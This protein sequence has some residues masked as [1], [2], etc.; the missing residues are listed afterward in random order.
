METDRKLFQYLEKLVKQSHEVFWIRNADYSKQLYINPAYE[1][2]WGRTCENLYQNPAEFIDTIL[3]EDR[4]KLE[5]DIAKRNPEVSPGDNFFTAYRIARPD[6]EIRWIEDES[7]AIFDD[8]GQ[9]LGFAGTA[10]DITE[11]KKKEIELSEAKEVAEASDRAKS[12]FIQ[13]M[14]HDVK[15]PL[16]GITSMADRIGRQLEEPEDLE[17]NYEN[18][19]MIKNS[20]REL[21]EFF[22]NCLEMVRIE[23]GEVALA[24]ENFNPQKIMNQL[25]EI[26]T[27]SMKQKGLG[28]NVTYDHNIPE[29]VYASGP[30]FYR[31]LLNLL[32]NAIKFTE[33][34]TIAVDI[35]LQK[36]PESDKDDLCLK[37][38]DTG[39]GI[40]QEKIATI[41]ERFTRLTP[42]YEG[43]FEGHGIG[44]Y[45]VH[46]FV[47]LMG[48][49]IDVS[50]ELGKGSCFTITF[51]FLPAKAF[52]KPRAVTPKFTKLAPLGDASSEG[53]ETGP[54][55]LLVEDNRMA[56]KGVESIL[57]HLGYKLDIVDTGKKALDI[58]ELDKYV[59][60][61]TDIGLDDMSGTTVA[62]HIRTVEKGRKN[63]VPIVALTA[64]NLKKIEAACQAAGI[65]GVLEKPLTEELAKEVLDLF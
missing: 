15:T 23:T 27:P 54:R 12:E 26:L 40:P 61:I 24:N 52:L 25:V 11:K 60:I 63:P 14:S 62:A 29:M 35:L 48:G 38:R 46:K 34:G 50:S 43:K 55:I 32:G 16:A 18:V 47:T 37:I 45:I 3:P 39:M 22:M 7:F 8:V 65:N 57:T 2:V 42:S 5:E 51:P 56:Q 9:H 53:E 44:L 19:Q 1:T 31:I 64:H 49:K 21:I 4:Q 20:V 10:I 6:G 41:F 30:G 13:N 17:D 33:E 28:F 58:F 36:N 59:L